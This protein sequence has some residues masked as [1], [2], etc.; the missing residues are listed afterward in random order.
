[1]KSLVFGFLS[2]FITVYASSATSGDIA[3]GETR[4][5]VNCFICHGQA[6]K[7]MASYPKLAGKEVAYLIDKL[8]TYRAGTRIGPNS[9]LMIMNAEPLSDEEIAN[10]AAYLSSL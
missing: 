10:L 8:E 6:G 9:D 1:M 4:Y 2:I 5:G 7:G 3:A